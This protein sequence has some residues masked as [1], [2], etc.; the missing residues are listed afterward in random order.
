MSDAFSHLT[1]RGR[2]ALARVDAFLLCSRQCAQ[3]H[4][5]FKKGGPLATKPTAPQEHLPDSVGRGKTKSPEAFA[6]SNGKI[7]FGPAHEE[8]DALLASC[9]EEECETTRTPLRSTAAKVRRARDSEWNIWCL[10]A[11][12]C[13][14]RGRKEG[15][16]GTH[17]VAVR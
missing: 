15:G 1:C 13:R 8:K 6:A 14:P 7:G 12:Y 5:K 17:Q 10:V 9:G 4:T 11:R 3:W 2:N 16:K